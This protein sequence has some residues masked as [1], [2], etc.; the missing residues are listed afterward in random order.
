MADKIVVGTDGS[1]ASLHAVK[2]AA[3]EAKAHGVELEVIHAWTV[4]AISDPMAMMPIQLPV[5]DFLK[6]AHVVCD[7]AVRVAKENG[8]T[9]VKATVARG[10][11][12]EHLITAS[13]A[14]SEVVVGTRGHGGF[15]GLLLGSV[16]QQVATHSSCPVVIVPHRK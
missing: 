1:D 10:S 15:V 5:D 13:R 2:W 7:N 11:A 6:Q 8:A 16:A 3:K 4:P 12:A 14:A 9:D